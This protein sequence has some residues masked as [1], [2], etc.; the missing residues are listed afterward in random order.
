MALE[1]DEVSNPLQLS[2][3]QQT[4]GKEQWQQEG[5]DH[6]GRMFAE[7]AKQIPRLRV[8]RL[9]RLEVP[10]YFAPLSVQH[11][12]DRQLELID[13]YTGA[14]REVMVTYGIEQLPAD[15]VSVENRN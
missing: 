11:L 15:M 8:D 12:T 14:I 1:Y 10:R 7:A 13:Q 3:D 6:I 5:L 9:G 2:K 4:K